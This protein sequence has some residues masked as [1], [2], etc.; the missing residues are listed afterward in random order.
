MAHAQITGVA[1]TPTPASPRAAGSTITLSAALTG[2]PV[3]TV[4]YQFLAN[5]VPLAAY[6]ISDT[7][8]W[9]PAAGSYSVRVKARDSGVPG[10]EYTSPAWAYTVVPP[11]S[12]A[13]VAWDAAAA[14]LPAQ[15]HITLTVAATGGANLRY[16]F[17]A[18]STVIQ[19]WSA[20][21]TYT[22]IP[23]AGGAFTLTAEVQD[24]NGDPS[25][26]AAT[27]PAPLAVTILPPLKSVTITTVQAPSKAY[28]SDQTFT[29]TAVPT[30]GSSVEYRY[31]ENGIEVRPFA[32]DAVYVWA[33]PAAG[34]FLLT[35]QARDL[36]AL[37]PAKVVSYNVAYTIADP[38]SVVSLT[39]APAPPGAVGTPVCFTAH[40]TGGA[41]VVYA[42]YVND[43]LVRSYFGRAYIWWTPASSGAFTIAVKVKD[44]GG[45][46]PA[47]VHEPAALSHVVYGTPTHLSFGVQPGTTVAGQI[48]A[49][50]VT[51]AVLDAWNNLVANDNTTLVTLALGTNP[52]G[53]TLSGSLTAV[54]IDGVATFSGISID[55]VGTGY[56]LS[57]DAIGLVGA[58]SNAFAIT[59]GPPAQLFYRTQP[60][61]TSAYMPFSPTVQVDVQDAYG[62][63]VPTATNAVTL[64]IGTN[65]GA[66]TLQGSKTISAVNGIATFG[67]TWITSAGVGYTL[68]ASATG[69]LAV[70]SHA[71]TIANPIL[72]SVALSVS[73][74]T[75]QLQGT[76]L[77]LTAVNTP[78]PPA[79]PPQIEYQFQMVSGGI[80][81]RTAWQTSPTYT[82]DTSTYNSGVWTLAAY[83][84][85]IEN[86]TYS[87]VSPGKGF[88]LTE[89]ILQAVQ[90]ATDKPSGSPVGTTVVVSA[91]K[92]PAALPG[93][94]DV[95][96]R[97][98][99]VKQGGAVLVNTAFSS[100]VVSY[101]W[102]TT[103]LMPGAYALYVY[104]RPTIS[105]SYTLSAS[106]L[107]ELK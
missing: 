75:P 73:P 72:D 99:I 45:A 105:K 49:P 39:A 88:T 31:L 103:G 65:P 95:E 86:T 9:A 54:A 92:T 91:N 53:G 90:V 98:M 2:A 38:I 23:Q 100:T 69:L 76:T 93:E 8:A 14:T 55:K 104:A 28:A 106:R 12:A 7:F 78:A 15:T 63:L 46:N 97:Y 40:V 96:Y 26:I 61:D 10:S 13:T 58:A 70:T 24:L 17:K 18:N 27:S 11:L 87:K 79:G 68:V 30:G 62:N 50:A 34:D 60:G 3:G 80:T 77:T 21:S 52:G 37:D 35:V 51:V 43:V 20:Y 25:P 102:N 33:P 36:D 82:W 83:A 42:F 44:L 5:N 16:Q 107:F 71:V 81:Y 85:L 57:A 74:A 47:L 4:T 101:T 64:A 59:P 41:R 32:A 66:G 84:R 6:D 56:T 22:W 19:P 67:K 89:P 94:T 48:I 1:L 29:L